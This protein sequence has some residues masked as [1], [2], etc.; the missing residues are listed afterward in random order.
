MNFPLLAV[1]KLDEI[2]EFFVETGATVGV[3]AVELHANVKSVRLSPRKRM[4]FL[5]ITFCS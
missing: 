3:D 1:T 2:V 4:N 5:F